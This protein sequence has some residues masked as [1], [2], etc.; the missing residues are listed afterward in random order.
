MTEAKPAS[1]TSYVFKIFK[2][3]D[4]GKCP[5]IFVSLMGRLRLDAVPFPF[6]RDCPSFSLLLDLKEPQNFYS[7]PEIC[8][9]M[10]T[11]IYSFMP[12]WTASYDT[13]QD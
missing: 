13:K 1:E 8:Q 12:S 6:R 3:T 10:L 2:L 4:K 7:S 5:R 9:P 11:F